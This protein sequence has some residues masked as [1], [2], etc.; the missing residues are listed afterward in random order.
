MVVRVDTG[1]LLYLLCCEY[2]RQRG[3]YMI[4]HYIFLEEDIL[5]YIFMYGV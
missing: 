5:F 2:P 1:I 3:K 4:G